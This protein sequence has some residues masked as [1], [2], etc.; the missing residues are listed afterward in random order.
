MFEAEELCF[1][2][3]WRKN[4]THLSKKLEFLQLVSTSDF[5]LHVKNYENKLIYVSGMMKEI[6][7]KL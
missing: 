4:W 7:K 3:V 2:A 6:K 1:F 5:G